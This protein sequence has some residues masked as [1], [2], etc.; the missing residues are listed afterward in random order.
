MDLAR[1]DRFSSLSVDL[2]RFDRDGCCG[3][4]MGMV[5]IS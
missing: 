5:N 2:A 1:F 3:T 4:V